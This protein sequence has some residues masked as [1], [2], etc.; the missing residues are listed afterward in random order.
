VASPILSSVLVGSI[1]IIAT[2]IVEVCFIAVASSVLNRYGELLRSMRLIP[3]TILAL[4]GLS[5]WLLAGISAALWLWAGL[6]MVLGEF[7]DLLD[8]I[9]FASVSA[10]TLGYGDITLSNDWKL[11][12]GFIAA[13]GLVLFS[14]NT[15]F[16]FEVLRRLNDRAHNR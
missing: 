11:L 3:R 5:F 10:T 2:V 4:G 1:V 15:A 8:A 7:E 14:L 9:Y 6:F 16:M 12:S 13:N